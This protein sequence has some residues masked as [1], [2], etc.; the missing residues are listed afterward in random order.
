[1]VVA[2]AARLLIVGSVVG[3][4]AAYFMS[5]LLASSLVGISAHDAV[6]FVGAWVLMTVVGLGASLIPAMYAARTD[7]NAVLHAE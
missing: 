3:L 7:L 4:A 1:M 2:E 6:S 5:R